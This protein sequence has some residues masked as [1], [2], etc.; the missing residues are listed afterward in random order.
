[1]PLGVFAIAEAEADDTGM[2]LQLAVSKEGIVAGT[3]HNE[4]GDFSRPVEGMVDQKSQR[5]AWRFADG[6]NE[7]L[8]METGIVNLTKDEATALVHFG[9]DRTETWT[10]VRLP[11]PEE[12][13]E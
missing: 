10:L 1:M 13:S 12:K 6:K 8:V 5:A 4:T 2:L 7:Q 9:Q 3:F 11:A